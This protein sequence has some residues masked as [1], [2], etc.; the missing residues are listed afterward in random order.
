MQRIEVQTG[1]MD[2]LEEQVTPTSAY[3]L[4]T[5]VER[6]AVDEYVDFVIEQ[7][8]KRHQ[9]VAGALNMP[10]PNEYIRRSRQALYR[11]IVRAAIAERITEEARTLDISPDRA[12][13]EFA[14]VAF[15]DI[16]DYLKAGY[17]GEPVIKDL[18]E[19]PPGKACAIKSIECEP[20][21]M[22]MK[23]KITL[24]DKLPALNAL[25]DMM[26]LTKQQERPV[27]KEYV[28]QELKEQERKAIEAPEVEYTELLE[29]VEKTG[30]K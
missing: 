14:T 9:P 20:R 3:D 4:L 15:S 13:H 12:V 2:S 24:H 7:Q 1:M 5:E 6:K 17:Y 11:P 21:T 18:S 27:L 30:I 19:M 29:S 23:W 26:G 16:T 22:G 10:I 8:R 25:A 28:A